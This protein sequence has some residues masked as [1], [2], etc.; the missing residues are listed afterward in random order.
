[1]FGVP[2]RRAAIV[3]IFIAY[4]LGI[5]LLASPPVESTAEDR[6]ASLA[7]GDA[8][9]AAAQ[10]THTRDLLLAEAGSVLRVT[11][12]GGVAGS[13]GN[14]QLHLETLAG[15]D[16]RRVDTVA[17]K[18]VTVGTW[19]DAHGN[20]LR[21]LRVLAPFDALSKS[22]QL[23]VLSESATASRRIDVAWIES[24]SAATASLVARSEHL[25]LATVVV[26][27]NGATRF[28]RHWRSGPLRV[29]I[30]QKDPCASFDICPTCR[31]A[32]VSPE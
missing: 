6:R 26:N 12:C 27:A 11:S 32:D 5:Q 25:P 31:W 22:R 20:A 1:M 13:A 28:S 29:S 18:H 17:D 15:S 4:T 16:S 9:S 10:D 3:C 19:R 8:A 23:A 21:I 14:T 2:Q 24:G 30:A 7:A